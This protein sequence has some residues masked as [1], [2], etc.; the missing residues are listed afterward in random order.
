M[1]TYIYT[2][3]YPFSSL[4]LALAA[5]LS[6]TYVHASPTTVSTR[7]SDG[8]RD[9]LAVIIFFFF[10]VFS[11]LSTRQTKLKK[12]KTTRQ[13]PL[14]EHVRRGNR[15]IRRRATTVS[16]HRRSGVHD[17]ARTG[18]TVRRDQMRMIYFTRTTTTRG[19]PLVPDPCTRRDIVSQ[20]NVLTNPGKPNRFPSIS[21]RTRSGFYPSHIEPYVFRFMRV[22]RKSNVFKRR[23]RNATTRTTTKQY[24]S[25]DH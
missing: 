21:S 3:K 19:T 18:W 5:P 20:T 13:G 4:R 14:R 2:C 15:A 10:F 6:R 1:Y 9:E 11:C 12:K 16:A 7:T 25:T 22:F 24:E 23:A 17:Q 8:N